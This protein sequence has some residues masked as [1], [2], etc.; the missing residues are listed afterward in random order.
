MARY[1]Q[2]LLA[3]LSHSTLPVKVR[4]WAPR[5]RMLGLLKSSLR[6][7][8]HFF[9]EEPPRVRPD[10]FHATACV[11][12]NWKSPVEVVTVHDLFAVRE[13]LHISAEETR[14][15]TDYIHRADR[16]ICVSQ[17]TRAHLHAL[18]DVP[19]E[20]SVAISLTAHEC[21]KPASAEQQ[22]RLRRR[23]GLPAEFLLFV[24]RYRTNKNLDGL[25]AAYAASGIRMPLYIV[26]IFSKQEREL[27]MRVAADVGCIGAIGWLNAVD[28]TELP[29]LLSCASALCLPST[30][31]GFGLPIIEAMACGTPVLTSAGRATEETAGGHAVLVDPESVESIADGLHRVLQM[32][33]TQRTLAREY[34]SRRTWNDVAAETLQAYA[35][36]YQCAGAASEPSR[37]RVEWPLGFSAQVS[38]D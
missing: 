23:Y 6:P 17:Y 32:T 29:T 5:R 25:L 13:E 27:T 1:T 4:P 2:S 15:R 20:K 19:E 7:P 33:D 11:F 37:T 30:F 22:L 14:R 9:S 18:L 3:A 21:F 16:I 36:A 35:H 26:G 34:A 28:E 12:P 31:E 10:I 8:V 24:G 38:V